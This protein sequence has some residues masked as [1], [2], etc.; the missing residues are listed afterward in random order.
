ML[1][2]S[3]S[4]GSWASEIP[5]IKVTEGGRDIER[6]RERKRMREIKTEGIKKKKKV[7]ESDRERRKRERVERGYED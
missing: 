4:T 6:E 1:L 7:R 2:S 3:K 5:E